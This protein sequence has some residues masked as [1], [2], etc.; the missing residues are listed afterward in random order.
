MAKEGAIYYLND[1]WFYIKPLGQVKGHCI[2]VR[3]IGRASVI[4]GLRCR[5]P[6]DLTLPSLEADPEAD[7]DSF[8]SEYDEVLNPSPFLSLN[9]ATD[10]FSSPLP[11]TPDS[12]QAEIQLHFGQISF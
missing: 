7:L 5:R 6:R 2:P 10:S 9:T 8:P 11:A 12:A 3:N 1:Q 4:G